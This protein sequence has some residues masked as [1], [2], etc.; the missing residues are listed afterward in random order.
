M[1]SMKKYDVII[2][3][4]GIS[5]FAAAIGARQAGAEVLLFDRRE[6]VGGTAVYALTPIISGW[7]EDQRGGG[8]ADMLKEYLTSRGELIWR[9][10]NADTEEDALQNAMQQ[11]L[12]QAGVDVLVNAELISADVTDKKIT[13]VTVRTPEGEIEL[14]ADNFVDASGDAV[15][16]VTA[17]ALTQVPPVELSMTKTLMFKVKNLKSFDKASI[18]ERFRK[19]VFPVAHQNE[20]MGTQLLNENEAILNL[21]AAI[22]NA[23]DPADYARMNDELA[24]QVPVIVEWLRKEFPEFAD[25]EVVKTAPAMGVRCSRSIVGRSTLD[26][27]D[28]ENTLPPPEP[29]AICGRYIGGHYIDCYSSP[30]GHSIPGNPA[31]PYGA[32][33]SKNI[34]NLLACGRIIDVDP[35]VISAVR[36][37]VSCMASGQAAG[38]AAALDMPE[39]EILKKE[40]IKQNCRLTK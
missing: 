10:G 34:D 19:K 21:T 23:V 28:M 24:A 16:A 26:L 15:L 38:V 29:V 5:G 7:P 37:C 2:A 31:I 25:I 32:L 11:L 1:S 33:R 20:F 9:N 14:F 8:V 40:L 17:G 36:L 27:S 3:G 30:W 13:S 6:S 12:A 22:G 39:Y 18:K 35:K 4:A